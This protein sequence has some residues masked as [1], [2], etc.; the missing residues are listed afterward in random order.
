MQSKFFTDKL[1]KQLEVPEESNDAL[2]RDNGN[3]RIT[4]T[5]VLQDSRDPK[6]S[7]ANISFNF[8]TPVKDNPTVTEKLVDNVQ[9]AIISGDL[10]VINRILQAMGM[11]PQSRAVTKKLE[12]S[13]NIGKY[14]RYRGQKSDQG[15]RDGRGRFV[16][17]V[18]L[19]NA[20]KLATIS[21]VVAEMKSPGTSGLVY[22]TGRLQYSVDLKPLVLKNNTLSVFFTYM[23]RPYSVFDPQVS[24]Y[25]GL[26]S[27]QRNPQKLITEQLQK[28]AAQ[29]GLTRYKIDIKQH[30]RLRG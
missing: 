6:E 4:E 2:A 12:I 25:R 9:E 30:Y 1:V 10:D 28:Q 14:S 15:L 7:L 20:L 18:N 23:V 19:R 29:L 21:N 5:V 16:S 22:R 24:R 26:S 13:T 8:K 27:N 17:E 3:L 11:Q